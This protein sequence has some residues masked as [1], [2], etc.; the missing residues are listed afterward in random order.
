MKH[1]CPTRHSSNLSPA[2][3]PEMPRQARPVPGRGTKPDPGIGPGPVGIAAPVLC[4]QH[5]EVKCP[6]AQ[7][8]QVRQR[9]LHLPIRQIL[10]RSEE[11]TSELQSLM[12]IPYSV[13]CLQKKKQ[14]IT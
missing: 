6:A 12:H 11:H 2:Q 7:A 13:F 14:T 9:A 8:T 3:G 4:R 5:A 1:F 10:Q